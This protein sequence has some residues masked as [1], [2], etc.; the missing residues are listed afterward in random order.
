MKAKERHRTK[1]IEFIGNPENDFPDR[2]E[3]ATS[4]LGFSQQSTLYRHFSSEELTEIERAGF[5]IRKGQTAKQRAQVYTALFNQAKKG[6]VQ[7]A[8]EY[9][10]R[11]EGKVA[12]K[13]EAK[14]DSEVVIIVDIEDAD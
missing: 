10:D 3:M 4:V 12:D 2:T 6:N 7:A 11:V 5:E 8:K 1:L 9:L 14:V 13:V